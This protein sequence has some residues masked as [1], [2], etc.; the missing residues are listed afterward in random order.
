MPVF[1]ISYFNLSCRYPGWRT[2]GNPAFR[3]EKSAIAYRQNLQKSTGSDA[4]AAVLTLP[5][6]VTGLSTDDAHNTSPLDNLAVT[7]N[8]FY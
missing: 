2:P 7:A 6:L 4:W 3:T 1:T 8:L 5:L